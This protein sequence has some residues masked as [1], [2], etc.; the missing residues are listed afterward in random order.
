MPEVMTDAMPGAMPDAM[1]DAMP[2][3]MTDTMQ[4]AV[5]DAPDA[6]FRLA[7]LARPV[8]GAGHV[9]VRIAASGVNPL[10][11]K[12]RAGAAGHARHPLPAV[13]GLD[14]AG[15]VEAVG[16][17]VARFRR[18]D[19]VYGT[20]G[21]VGGIQGTLA[22][23][24]A[25]DADL[26]AHKPANLTMRAAAA[27]PLVTLTAWEGLV[28]RMA[29]QPGQTVLIQG[30]AGGVGHVA[31]QIARAF[32]A[33]VFATGSPG[34]R[35]T[36]EQFGAQFVDRH[37]PVADYVAR[38][39][40]GRGFDRVF[41][42]VGGAALDASFAAVRRFGHVASSLGWGTHALAPLSFKGATYSGVFTLMPLLSGEGRR[43]HGEILAEAAALA[44]AGKLVPRVDPRRFD[45]S[46]VGDAHQAI[47]DATARGKLFRRVH[48]AAAADRRRSP[49]SRRDPARGDAVGRER[50]GRAAPRSAPLHARD[51]R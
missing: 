23:L 24:A 51:D 14:L 48:A 33:E 17:G 36:I 32:G 21:G 3:A 41:D 44:L 27:L 26:L 28:D 25:V 38:L 15:T 6:P 30:G 37:E 8:V 18:G 39:T 20:T 9:L 12:I 4:A 16:D 46:T 13:L 31:I 7:R 5:L 45:L 2:G 10:D 40:A 1:P 11:T 49:T 19:E 47:R 42:T 35:A 22:E 34:D 50:Q 43:H 29:V